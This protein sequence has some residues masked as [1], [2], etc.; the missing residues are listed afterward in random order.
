MDKTEQVENLVGVLVEGVGEV[1][2]SLGGERSVKF[3]VI[4]FDVVSKSDI[5]K[6]V[7]LEQIYFWGR[8]E[9]NQGGIGIGFSESVVVAMLKLLG[10]E[11]EAVS[12]ELR[13]VLLEVCEA[14][15]GG[16]LGKVCNT[17]GKGVIQFERVQVSLKNQPVSSIIEE[18]FVDNSIG[19]CNIRFSG[20]I[21][22]GVVTIL[23]DEGLGSWFGIKFGG[24]KSLDR[25]ERKIISEEEV[26]NFLREELQNKKY[27]GKEGMSESNANMKNLGVILGIEVEVVARLGSVEMPLSS[28]LSLGPGSVVNVGHLVDEPIELY[29]N[30]KLIAR[31]DVVIVDEKFG[32]RIT[33]VV[34]QEER[35]ESLR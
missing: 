29:V 21:T 10:N 35:I 22:E 6:R 32:V 19:I 9:K 3:E 23:F 7:E 17:L 4:S 5:G 16:V 25:S 28:V 15:L 26:E 11:V 24:E 31:G 1:V 34:S 13:Q 2:S 8:I 33:E 30:N 20:G 14:L 12:E 18:F 27:K